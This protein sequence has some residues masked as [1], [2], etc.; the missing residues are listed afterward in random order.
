MTTA[1]HA[2]G[3]GQMRIVNHLQPRGSEDVPRFALAGAV[4]DESAS[5]TPTAQ[6][7]F[8]GVEQC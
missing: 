7:A 8:P 1:H 3:G 5:R 6:Y 2:V 4:P